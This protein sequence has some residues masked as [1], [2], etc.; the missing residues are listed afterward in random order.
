MDNELEINN[1]VNIYKVSFFSR[2]PTNNIRITYDLTIKTKNIILVEDLI[3]YLT[4]IDK[5]FHEDIADELLSVFG[6]YQTLQAEHH[7]V[8]LQTLRTT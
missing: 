1:N 5:K 6:G 3:N 2:C 7:G 4:N 8:F